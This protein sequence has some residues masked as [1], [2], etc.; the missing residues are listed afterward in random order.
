MNLWIG[1]Y[2]GLRNEIH[3]LEFKLTDPLLSRD[4]LN[5]TQKQLDDRIY[6][7]GQFKA[8]LS[9]FEDLENRILFA[10]YVEG[11][12]LEQ[13]AEEIGYSISHIKKRHA[14]IMRTLS[15]FEKIYTKLE[16]FKRNYPSKHSESK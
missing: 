1:D 16:Q 6:R 13:V 12:T 2:L 5:H 8:I 3:Y 15:N 14:E 11:K 10:R 7:E 4:E 9:S